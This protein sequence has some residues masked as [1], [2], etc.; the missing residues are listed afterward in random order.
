MLSLDRIAE[1]ILK[2][3]IPANAGIQIENLET[4]Q[5]GQKF[6][7][8]RHPGS[9][10]ASYDLGPGIRRDERNYWDGSI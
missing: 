1:V 6:G 10:S 8:T 5:I 3:L 7:A 4:G 9:N 2:P